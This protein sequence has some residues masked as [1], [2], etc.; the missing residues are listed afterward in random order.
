MHVLDS[1]G[2]AMGY[3]VDLERDEGRVKGFDRDALYAPDHPLADRFLY[4]FNAWL[5]MTALINQMARSLGQP[6][7]YPFVIPRPVVAKLHFVQIVVLD[8][9]TRADL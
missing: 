7:F 2:T 6:D 4:W 1:L 8:A 3:G 9:Q 5:R